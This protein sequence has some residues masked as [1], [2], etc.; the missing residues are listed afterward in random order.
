MLSRAYSV[1]HSMRWKNFWSLPRNCCKENIAKFCFPCSSAFC[2]GH[3][4][5]F[6]VT[7]RLQNCYKTGLYWHFWQLSASPETSRAAIVTAT[8]HIRH[9]AHT[10]QGSVTTAV[11]TNSSRSPGQMNDLSSS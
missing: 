7:A 11:V 3:Y 9:F 6:H 5:Q 10:A 8:S 4:C 2:H 1:V